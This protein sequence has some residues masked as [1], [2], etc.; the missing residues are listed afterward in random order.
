MSNTISLFGNLTRDPELSS[1]QGGVPVAT[2]SIASNTRYRDNRG[3]W[4]ERLNGFLTV[5]V[6]GDQGERVAELFRKGTR[7]T[8]YGE[9]RTRTYD[10]DKGQKHYVTEV[11]AIEIGVSMLFESDLIRGTDG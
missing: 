11:R 10:D 1:T 2:M 9:V 3:E 4:Q 5:K 8:V 7:V 6:W